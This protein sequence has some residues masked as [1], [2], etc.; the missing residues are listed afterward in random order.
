MVSQPGQPRSSKT[1]GECVNADIGVLGLEDDS[2]ALWAEHL[3]R[4]SAEITDAKR[5]VVAKWEHNATKPHNYRNDLT[6][7]L[8]WSFISPDLESYP[9]DN[10]IDVGQRLLGGEEAVDVVDGIKVRLVQG[11]GALYHLRCSNAGLD[12]RNLQ[13]TGFR[14]SVITNAKYIA[15]PNANVRI[16]LIVREDL[17]MALKVLITLWTTPYFKAWIQLLANHI[18]LLTFSC[19]LPHVTRHVVVAVLCKLAFLHSIKNYTQF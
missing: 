16:S 8:R 11:V 12:Y 3:T 9:V 18:G 1:S 10:G 7:S 2:A 6:Q 13:C 14:R 17:K 4:I 15:A 19:Q 5:A